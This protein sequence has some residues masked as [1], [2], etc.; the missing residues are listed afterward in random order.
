[1]NG[2]VANSSASPENQ[3]RGEFRVPNHVLKALEETFGEPVNHVKVFEESRFARLHG[4]V[5]A[6]TRRNRI[7]LTITGEEFIANEELV[8]HE[9]FHVIRQWNTG[10]LTVFRYTIESMRR[11]YW[12]NRFEVKAREFAEDNLEEFRELLNR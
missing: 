7:Y 4:Y 2:T 3:R 10:E 8:L 9:Y 12:N 5:L 6:T 11:R 1:V